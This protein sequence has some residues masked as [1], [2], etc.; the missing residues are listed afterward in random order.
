MLRRAKNTLEYAKRKNV[1]YADFILLLL[2]FKGIIIG[3]S[4]P[5][6]LDIF[7]LPYSS[8]GSYIEVD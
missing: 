2:T 4:F 1:F 5:F 3:S 8:N 6:C 7:N